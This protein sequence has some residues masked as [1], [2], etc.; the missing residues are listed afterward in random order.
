MSAEKPERAVAAEP[1]A[2]AV[3]RDAHWAAKM[4]RL[5]R[6]KLPERTVRFVDDPQVK[7][8]VADAALQLAKARAD[9]ERAA[10]ESGVAG[11][12]R[13]EWIE[14]QPDVLAADAL[15]AQANAAL[16]EET[17]TVTFRALPCPAW[18]TLLQDHPPTEEGADKGHEYNV[19]TFPAAL[20]SASSTDGMTVEEAQE[21]LD[22]WGDA[23]AKSLF[24]AALLVNQTQRA[25]L[26]KG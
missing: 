16:E 23:D 4:E 22:A 19:D 5:R 18:E 9:A 12:R 14:G 24:T 8:S 2:L 1:P 13:E 10:E 3:A 6:R 15:L 7:R 26:G 11:G 17:I 21:L 20:V 25:D